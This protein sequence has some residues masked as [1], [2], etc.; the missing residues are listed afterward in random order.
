MSLFLFVIASR[1]LSLA[2]SRSQL[3][4]TSQLATI[5]YT[6]FAFDF[7][8]RPMPEQSLPLE[9]LRLT[10]SPSFGPFSSYAKRF[11]NAKRYGPAQQLQLL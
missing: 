7:T 4:F 3:F 8:L 1:S 5:S 9:I 2:L 10:L 6:T 11:D